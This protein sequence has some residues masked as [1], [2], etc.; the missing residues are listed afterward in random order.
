MMCAGTSAA[1]VAN[2][3]SSSST[4]KPRSASAVPPSRTEAFG[5]RMPRSRNSDSRSA[6][7]CASSSLSAPAW[8]LPTS[9]EMGV[10][11]SQAGR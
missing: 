10:R 11:G 4:R 9:R 1:D 2:G 8:R 7:L 6:E 5:K 3:T